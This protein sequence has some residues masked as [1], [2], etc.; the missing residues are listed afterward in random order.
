MHLLQVINM[1]HHL[2]ASLA[3]MKLDDV[4]VKKVEKPFHD[5]II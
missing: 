2:Q 1:S 3:G 5:V 4:L